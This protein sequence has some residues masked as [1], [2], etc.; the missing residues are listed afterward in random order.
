MKDTEIFC[1]KYNSGVLESLP[2]CFIFKNG[3]T[4]KK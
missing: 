2:E 3:S 1:A 4:S